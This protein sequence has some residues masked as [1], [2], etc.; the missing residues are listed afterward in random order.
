M[1]NA[2]PPYVS[3]KRIEI[4]REEV[5]GSLTLQFILY[6]LNLLPEV[7][8]AIGDPE[9]TAFMHGF[10]AAWSLIRNVQKST[11]DNFPGLAT[12]KERGTTHG[13]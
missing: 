11:H 7:V 3:Q 10:V 1:A 5:N 12:K 4:T 9:R 6:D 8:A 13:D 2:T